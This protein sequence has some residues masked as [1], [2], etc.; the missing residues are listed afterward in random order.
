MYECQDWEREY[1][2]TPQGWLT[3]SSYVLGEIAAEVEPPSDRV[4]TL[5]EQSRFVS[6][7]SEARSDW[8]YDWKSPEIGTDD[9]HKLLA[10]FGHRPQLEIR[11]DN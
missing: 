5:V 8:R 7:L 4:L 1:H 3:G 2:L 11:A 9:P 6:G 10:M